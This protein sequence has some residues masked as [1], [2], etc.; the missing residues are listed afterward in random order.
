MTE[1]S[2]PKLLARLQKQR[3]A[4]EGGEFPIYDS[5]IGYSLFL[6]LC[7]YEV[8]GMTPR[9]KDVYVELER[10]Q[11]GVRRLVRALMNDGWITILKSD[12]DQRSRYIVP[13]PKLK[14][15]IARFVHAI[16]IGS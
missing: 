1:T 12:G 5:L 4:L 2:K 15:A 16:H 6:L 13:T 3:K 14:Q 9:L 10:S 11:G 8:R 7:H